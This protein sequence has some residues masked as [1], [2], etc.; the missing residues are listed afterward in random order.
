[1]ALEDVG[2]NMRPHD[3]GKFWGY[4]SA[5]SVKFAPE[6]EPEQYGEPLRVGDL[7]GVKLEY[8]G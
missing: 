2:L 1:M 4:M 3:S 8:A 5:G 6:K 7:I